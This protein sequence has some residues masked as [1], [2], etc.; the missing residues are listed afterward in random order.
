[1]LAGRPCTMPRHAAA[2]RP[3]PRAVTVHASRVAEAA[4]LPVKAFDGADVG[5]A[6]LALKV[7][8]DDT[9]RHVVHRYLVLV[10]QN[11]RQ[12][13]SAASSAPTAGPHVQP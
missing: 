3:A 6:N 2:V 1:M 9:A 10:N 13:R 5:T 8:G 11:A 7:A 12:V 4:V